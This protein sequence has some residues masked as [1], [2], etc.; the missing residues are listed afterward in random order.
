MDKIYKI[1]KIIKSTLILGYILLIINSLTILFKA[2]ATGYEINIY[3]VY[4]FYFWAFFFLTFICSTSVILYL[5]LSYQNSK[6]WLYWL[7]S[8][9]QVILTYCII[10]LIPFFRGY[11]TYGRWDVL[12][13]L[14]WI[15]DIISSGHIAGAGNFGQ[16]F[17]PIIHIYLSICYYFLNV[18]PNC[19]AEVFPIF[20]DF[21]YLL[22]IYLLAKEISQSHQASLLVFAFS[23]P[24]MYRVE[25]IM[26]AP[27]VQCF[28]MLPFILFLY[29]KGLTPT[30][31]ATSY[32]FLFTLIL[33]LIPFLHP[34]EGALFL[35]SILFLITIFHLCSSFINH[36]S[37]NIYL[38]LPISILA[39]TWFIWFSSFQSFGY[40]MKKI[41][42]FLLFDIGI[43][44][45]MKD[46]S[47]LANAKL[48]IS[49]FIQLFFNIYGQNAI[50]FVVSILVCVI[51]LWKLYRHSIGFDNYLTHYCIIFI[52]L[53]ILLFI[54]YF[55]VIG[56]EYTREMRYLS[57]ISGI[58]NG[59]GL[60]YVLKNYS[61]KIYIRVGTYWLL[62]ML[63][64]ASL[65]FSLFN[66]FPSPSIQQYNYQVTNMEFKGMNWFVHYG[67]KN[68]TVGS[69]NL[70]RWFTTSLL[71][72][73]NEQKANINYI[74]PVDHFNYTHNT[75][76][77]RYGDSFYSDQ[78]FIISRVSL[79]I[80]KELFANY[81]EFWSFNPIDFFYFNCK[82]TSILKLY[83]N[84]EFSAYYVMSDKA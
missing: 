72:Q 20:Y 48:S 76:K 19:I 40:Q 33:L 41:L 11:V 14:G 75:H 23:I 81:K 73:E 61:L 49:E 58:L 50:S 22:F 26:L 65:F 18:D 71:G 70:A 25:H 57:F 34:G 54:S 39:A 60:F 1:P 7:L 9:V 52:I 44:N 69:F 79:I 64:I 59:F 77:M 78:Y 74:Y 6:F 13:H 80:H 45:S 47:I 38:F 2:Q 8:F 30:N 27:S 66:I 5:A 55:S 24:F 62:Y 43:S 63:L 37:I 29:Y 35:L 82:D 17:Y 31:C 84:G 10:L 83:S 4:P 51:V 36:Q 16:N 67:D 42:G 53:L 3:N 68:M 32:R 56:V 12:D 15:K 46:A 21:I 28:F